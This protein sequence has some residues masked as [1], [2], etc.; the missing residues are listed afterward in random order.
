MPSPRREVKSI[1]INEIALQLTLKAMEHKSIGGNS[2]TYVE[3][4]A[5]FY[6]TLI[7]KINFDNTVTISMNIPDEYTK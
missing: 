4:V 3:N 5:A 7:E 1:D 2:G 6:N